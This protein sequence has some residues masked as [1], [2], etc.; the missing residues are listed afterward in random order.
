[1][2]V[3]YIAMIS[4][5][6]T[7]MSGVYSKR[8]SSRVGNKVKINPLR[9][10]PPPKETIRFCHERSDVSVVVGGYPCVALPRGYFPSHHQEV[11]SVSLGCRYGDIHG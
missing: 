2:Q 8:A 7:L 1:M 4:H 9:P 11:V 3:K 5:Q 6:Q 10:F